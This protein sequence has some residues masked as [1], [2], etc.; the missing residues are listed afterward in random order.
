MEEDR[1]ALILGGLGVTVLIS[2]IAGLLGGTLGFGTVILRRSGKK[3]A[4][5]LVDGYQAIMSG[6]P[7]VVWLMLFYYVVFGSIDVAGE[8]V[9]IIAFMLVFAATSGTTMWT[10]IQ[11]IDPI[12]EKTGL[13]LGYTRGEVFRK[14][15]FPQ[16][17]QR[18]LPQLLGQFVGLLKETAV[19]G[20]IAV[21][22]LARASDLIRSRTMDAF[23]PLVATAIIYFVACRV[24]AWAIGRFTTRTQVENRPRTIEGVDL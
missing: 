4:N 6:V 13:A 12:Q 20:Y 19:V 18:F 9:A 11:G 3:W 22:D 5:K 15:I 1:W 24:L 23:F 16:A 10:A 14:I 8:F 21:C 2:V 7:I 17:M